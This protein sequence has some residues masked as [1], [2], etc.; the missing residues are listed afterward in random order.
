M[1]SRSSRRPARPARRRCASVAPAATG[2]SSR[3]RSPA[4]RHLHGERRR[5]RPLRRHAGAARRGRDRLP[6]TAPTTR[7]TTPATT[8]IPYRFAPAVGVP[9]GDTPTIPPSFDCGAGQ[10]FMPGTALT[11]PGAFKLEVLP[12]AATGA[13]QVKTTWLDKTPPVIKSIKARIDKPWGARQR[14]ADRRSGGHRRRRGHRRSQRQGRVEDDEV[15]RRHADR[16]DRGQGQ[17]ERAHQGA[18]VGHRPHDPR[19]RRRP[20]LGR[21]EPEGLEAQD[22]AA[23]RDHVRPEGRR[24]LLHGADRAGRDEAAR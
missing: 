16:P 10:V 8:R 4:R 19:R 7:S 24:R 14:H 5:L 18:A 22:D 21:Q 17:G 15:R 20:V 6:G 9:C 11:V 12:P 2:S 3:G 23:G 1:P 13:S